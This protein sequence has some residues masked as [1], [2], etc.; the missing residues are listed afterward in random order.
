MARALQRVE[1]DLTR[2][3]IL[4]AAGQVFADRGYHAA[5]VR[6]V[7]RLAGAN[8][9]AVNYHFRD[10]LG[11]YQEVLQQSARGAKK[12]MTAAL[13]SEGSPE[14]ILRAVVKARLQSLFGDARHDWQFRIMLHEVTQ[15]TPVM[16][17]VV[18]EIMKPIYARM[19]ALIGQILGLPPDHDKTRL[20]Q[21][22]IMGQILLYPLAW[23]LLEHFWP[24]LK[25]SPAQLERIAEHIADFSL[26]YL[27]QEGAANR[28]QAPRSKGRK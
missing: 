22:S 10:K 15:P 13:E 7:C 26:A 17:R 25:K 1:V 14:E 9:A 20:C 3:K 12:G 5:T 23:P 4:E 18:E 8:V 28:K 19:L 11:L 2:D 16:A 27:K 24:Q 21:Q 6:D